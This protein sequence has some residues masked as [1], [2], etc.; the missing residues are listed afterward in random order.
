MTLRRSDVPAVY[1]ITDPARGTHSFLA[2]ELCAAGV[3][4]IQIREK[5]MAD[6]ALFEEVQRALAAVHGNATIF[7]NDRADVAIASGAGGVHVGDEDMPPRLIRLAAGGRPLLVRYSTH[8]VEDA[9]A[10]AREE[11]IDYIA[12]G[13][14]FRSPTRVGFRI[15]DDGKKVRFAKR[16]GEIIP[17]KN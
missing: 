12:V 14:I 5:E 3:R 6:R 7:V 17:E 15:L 9:A 11:A 4:W 1:A 8:S 16:S 2:A 13:P 10:A